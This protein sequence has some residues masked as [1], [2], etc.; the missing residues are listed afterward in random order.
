MR[1]SAS[2]LINIFMNNLRFRKIK[3]IIEVLNNFSVPEKLFNVFCITSSEVTVT[4]KN[5]VKVKTDLVVRCD[6]SF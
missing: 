4:E 6:K 2:K 3:E 1:I 5:L